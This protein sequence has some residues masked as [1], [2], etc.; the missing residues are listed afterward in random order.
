VQSPT[1]SSKG[2]IYLWAQAPG[3]TKPRAYRLPYD[4]Q[5]EKQVASAAHA[6]RTGQK[7]AIRANK[8]GVHAK[9]GANDTQNAGKRLRFYK[10]PLAGMQAKESEAGPAS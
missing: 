5:L 2:A 4:P 1:P 9:S 6:S 8:T 7:V 10:L 3:A